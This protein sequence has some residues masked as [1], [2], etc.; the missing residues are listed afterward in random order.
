MASWC[1]VRGPACQPPAPALRH[2]EKAAPTAAERRHGVFPA[3][4]SGTV[5]AP[6]ARTWRW[7]CGGDDAKGADHMRWP[8]L[9]YMLDFLYVAIASS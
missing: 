4:S 2:H 7:P 6:Q 8:P 9:Q 5:E 3:C 1:S